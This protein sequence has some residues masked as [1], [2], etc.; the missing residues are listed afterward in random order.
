MQR[1]AI[2]DQRTFID[3]DAH[4]CCCCHAGKFIATAFPTHQR[5]VLGSE[6]FRNCLYINEQ[7]ICG[8]LGNSIIQH[9]RSHITEVYV[10]VSRVC[11]SP[12]PIDGCSHGKN[13]NWKQCHKHDTKPTESWLG[14]GINF[15]IAELPN[16]PPAEKVQRNQHV[17]DEAKNASELMH[18]IFRGNLK[19]DQYDD[20][21]NIG[22]HV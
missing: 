2:L 4:R 16:Q 1:F 15:W 14:Y 6:K 7:I 22:N 9:F 11:I 3:C 17:Y 20:S 18:Q 8:N 12:L 5:R 13:Y 10:R 21:E 19:I